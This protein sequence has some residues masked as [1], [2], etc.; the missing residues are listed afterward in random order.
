[1]ETQKELIK[2]IVVA[3][4]LCGIKSIT[5]GGLYWALF[6][7]KVDVDTATSTVKYALDAKIIE[8]NG[9]VFFLK[10]NAEKDT[11][12]GQSVCNS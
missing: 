6:S 7:Q 5:E 10:S 9:C 2:K 4:K 12:R 11:C 3:M 1:M 8:R